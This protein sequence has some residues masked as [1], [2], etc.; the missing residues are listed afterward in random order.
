MTM[1]WYRRAMLSSSAAGFAPPTPRFAVLMVSCTNSAI[2]PLSQQSILRVS[3]FRMA[4]ALVTPVMRR[5]I[6]AGKIRA[7]SELFFLSLT[8]ANLAANIL[9]NRLATPPFGGEYMPCG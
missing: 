2:I 1:E 3:R 5:R 7:C 9:M 4:F 8:L 6:T